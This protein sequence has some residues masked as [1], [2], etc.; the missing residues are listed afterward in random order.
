[1]RRWLV[2][3]GKERPPTK[4]TLVADLPSRPVLA[5]ITVE[6]A[7]DQPDHRQLVQ[8]AIDALSGPDLERR[9]GPVSTVLSGE[10]H[11][12]LHAVERAHAVMADDTDRVTTT[13]RIESRTPSLSLAEREQ[14]AADLDAREPPLVDEDSTPPPSA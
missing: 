1:M 5:E 9:V 3:N 4:G 6:P 2:G 8:S 13:V 11:D 12:V 14:E 7:G 10:L